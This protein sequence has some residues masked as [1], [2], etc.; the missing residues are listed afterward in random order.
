MSQT[1]SS[2]NGTGL[3]ADILTTTGDTFLAA[4]A[5]TVSPTQ[6]ATVIGQTA[7]LATT[8]NGTGAT[9]IVSSTDGVNI[10]GAVIS[11]V[12]ASGYVAGDTI[13]VTKVDMDADASIGTVG[14]DLVI[15]I[16]QGD[17][18]STV[19]SLTVVDPGTGYANLD[20]ITFAAAD[21]GVSVADLVIT[22]VTADLSVELEDAIVVA[23]GTGYVI[24]DDVTVA[25]ALIGSP[26]A[27]LV[28]D[29]V[30]DDIVNTNVFTLETISEGTVM[31]SDGTNQNQY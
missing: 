6:T 31:N 2:G 15:T 17:L 3:S 8:G 29:L 12:G 18:E 11:N 5:L 22:V 24:G 14:A 20:T 26:S 10:T 21:V 30:A 1:S 27:D 13:T 28:F 16:A 23:A 4:K 9:V 25:L 7:A 19:T